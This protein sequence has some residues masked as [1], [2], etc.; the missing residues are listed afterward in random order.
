MFACNGILFNH[1]SP[2]RGETFVT[3]KITRAACRIAM[4]LQDICYLGNLDAQ[5]DWGH[6]KDYVKAMWLI[7]QQ[8]Q[9]EDYVIATGITTTVREFV[10]K[11]FDRLGIELDFTGKGKEEIGK[12]SKC[13]DSP[14]QLPIGKE[15]VK[16]DPNYYRPTEVDMLIGDPTKAKKQLGWELEYNLNDLIIDMVDSDLKIVERDQHLID[17]GHKVMKHHE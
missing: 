10:I 4:G 13:N 14:F 17:G 2:I 11:S 1:E 6:A 8:K 3:R 5:R 15:V 9:P 16:V 12:V 7:L